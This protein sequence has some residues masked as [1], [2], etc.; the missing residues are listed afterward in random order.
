MTIAL[1][2]QV[3][4]YSLTT[5]WPERG[6]A[7]VDAFLLQETGDYLLLE[8]GDK[9]ILQ[10]S[11][12]INILLETANGTGYLVQE[13]GTSKITAYLETPTTYSPQQ[14]NTRVTDYSLSG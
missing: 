4:N 2:T 10:E 7:I 1:T 13:D 14:L 3:T 11:N 8:Y 12:P 9:I 5:N 6:D